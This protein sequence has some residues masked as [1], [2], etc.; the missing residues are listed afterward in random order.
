MLHLKNKIQ[1]DSLIKLS[2]IIWCIATGWSTALINIMMG[3]GLFFIIA[4]SIISN[5]KIFSSVL[6]IFP[7]VI[8][9][10]LLAVSSLWSSDILLSLYNL[11]AY[12]LFL[13]FPIAITYI[14]NIDSNTISIGIKYL[15][16]SLVPA[17]LVTLLWNI[18]STETASQL[19]NHL[20]EGIVK[21]FTFSNK[22]QFG[23]YVPFMERIHFANLLSLSGLAT[24][25]LFIKYKKWHYI[26]LAITLLSG[27]FVLGA[28]AA[29][30]G[31]LAF[32]PFAFIY[33]IR[34]FSK[35]ISLYIIV[36]SILLSSCTTYLLY[37]G[38]LTRYHQTKYELETIKNN[39]L[40]EN[41]YAH[42][43]TFTRI[44]SWTQAWEMWK[45]KPTF[46]YGIGNYLQQYE[47]NYKQEY[48]ELPMTY[49]SQ[50]LYFLGI[51]GLL[52][53][54]IFLSMY[55]YF[56]ISLK[57]NFSK[58]YFLC[59]SIYTFCVWFFDTGLLQKKEMM[60]FT[61]FLCFAKWL[62]KSEISS[63]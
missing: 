46:G 35:K 8:L 56:G 48:P 3:L 15:V 37:P 39:Q 22:F 19:S 12:L 53:F 21:P 20:F 2:V 60:A 55:I 11:K 18:I 52:G 49:H 31:V 9:F 1:L 16:Y 29:L 13:L 34:Q 23:W 14:D 45:E 36:F 4:D 42:F 62:E 27:P 47:D 51:F 32:M 44:V 58:I 5:R 6:I 38:I 40:A 54:I 28:R 25:F 26:V 7:T 43:S 41:D 59:F 17:Y 33:F 10:F 30:L 50:F 24:I 57:G 61:L 63:I